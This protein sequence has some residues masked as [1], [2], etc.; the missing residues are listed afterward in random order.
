MAEAPLAD[1]IVMTAAVAD[2]RVKQ[3]SMVKIK[4]TTNPMVLELTPTM[5]ILQEIGKRKRKGQILVGF[6]LETDNEL[7]N[8][9]LKLKKKHLDF[10]VLNSLNEKGAG[11][12]LETNKITIIDKQGRIQQG[13]L[14]TKQEVAADIL[15]AISEI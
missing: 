13:Q 8:A 9:K 5:D 2:Y 7:E 3:P 15:D 14:K 12:G 11:F 1:I 6:A 4:K 10:I